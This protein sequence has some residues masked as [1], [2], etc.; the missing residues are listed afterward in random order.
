MMLDYV[1]IRASKNC[2]AT[3]NLAAALL[4]S[5]HALTHDVLLTSAQSAYFKTPSTHLKG[6][7]YPADVS[8]AIVASVL[9]LYSFDKSSASAG[10]LKCQLICLISPIKPASI[11]SFIFVNL[12]K[13]RR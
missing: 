12:G 5:A 7:L 9:Q 2:I 4:P 11:H 6:L 1:V 13:L 10:L 8:G 3:P